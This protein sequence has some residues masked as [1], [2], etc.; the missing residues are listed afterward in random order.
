MYKGTLSRCLAAVLFI[1]GCSGGSTSTETTTTVTTT[2]TS[3]AGAETAEGEREAPQITWSQTERDQVQQSIAGVEAP[4]AERSAA[5]VLVELDAESRKWNQIAG[6][7]CASSEPPARCECMRVAIA[8]G[9]ALVVL[10]SGADR[11]MAAKALEGIATVDANVESCKSDQAIVAF[12]RD[13]SA[14]RPEVVA[15]ARGKTGEA[16]LLGALGHKEDAHRLAQQ[17]VQLARG[18]G[19]GRERGRALI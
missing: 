5:A 3:G 12:E 11:E 1:L 17:A 19:A 16:E 13:L 8:Q 9:D 7:A 6:D 4:H 2:T 18:A 14:D 15:E 10:L